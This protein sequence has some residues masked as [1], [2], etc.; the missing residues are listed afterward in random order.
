MKKNRTRSMRSSKLKKRT[1]GKR[2]KKKKAGRPTSGKPVIKLATLNQ[3]NRSEWRESYTKSNNWDLITR[4]HLLGR[5]E[6]KGSHG[7][8]NL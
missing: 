4:D 2:E 6:R 5:L 7:A 8:D 3:T 1:K